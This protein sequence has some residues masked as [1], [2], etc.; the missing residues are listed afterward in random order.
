MK[1]S[2]VCNGCKYSV[3]KN[4]YH[5][6]DNSCEYCLVNGH[7]RTSVERKNGGYKTDSC[8]CYEK[9]EPIKVRTSPYGKDVFM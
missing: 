7:S 6:F 4:Y 2:K 8:V 1:D 5:S 3:K 9:G